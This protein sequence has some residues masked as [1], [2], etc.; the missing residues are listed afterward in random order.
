MGPQTQINQLS[1]LHKDTYFFYACVI[2]YCL[3]RFVVEL[4]GGGERGG[5]AV[6]VLTCFTLL[7]KV[8]LTLR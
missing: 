7:S 1:Q 5:G 8:D 6:L 2:Y 4:D 3:C